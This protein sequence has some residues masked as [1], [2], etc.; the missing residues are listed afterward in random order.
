MGE[1]VQ[2]TGNKDRR[3]DNDNPLSESQQAQFVADV[4]RLS[5]LSGNVAIDSERARRTSRLHALRTG[6]LVAAQMIQDT[7]RSRTTFVKG[8][9]RV[10]CESTDSEVSMRYEIETPTNLKRTRA[11]I[12]SHL[13]AIDEGEPDY[14]ESLWLEDKIAR[15]RKLIPLVGETKVRDDVEI[16]TERQ[17]HETGE[18]TTQV[19]VGVAKEETPKF[20]QGH[21]KEATALKARIETEHGWY[22]EAA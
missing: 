13:Y 8:N 4:R 11:T 2:F 14:V 7:S 18:R 20:T 12:E 5:K 16:Q 22:I 17:V 1:I 6:S 15:T 19:N 10:I 3:P 21:F 9:E